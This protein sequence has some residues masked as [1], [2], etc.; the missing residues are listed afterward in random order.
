MKTFSILALAPRRSW[1][2]AGCSQ[3]YDEQWQEGQPQTLDSCRQYLK[4][5]YGT[6]AMMPFQRSRGWELSN[7]Q[8]MRQR[9]CQQLRQLGADP[10]KVDISNFSF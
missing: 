8:V 1:T 3:G 10:N 5:Q 6:A 4:Q 2:P 9:C 7:C